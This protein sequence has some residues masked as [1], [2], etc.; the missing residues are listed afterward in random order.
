MSSLGHDVVHTSDLPAGNRTDD[1]EVS[2]AADAGD[3]IGVTKDRDFL[4]SHLLGGKPARLLL[5][6]TGNISNNDLLMVFSAAAAVVDAAF[7]ENCLVEIS[8]TAVV[9]HG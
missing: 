6:A 1:A 9:I 7:E 8:P 4:D 2:R 5:V 3:R